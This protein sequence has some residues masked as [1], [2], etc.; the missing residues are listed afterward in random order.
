PMGAV[1]N[2]RRQ[3][4]NAERN[5]PYVAATPSLGTVD[6]PK[7][8]AGRRPPTP[9]SFHNL[10]F[11]AQCSSESIATLSG[12]SIV[13]AITVSQTQRQVSEHDHAGRYVTD[14]V[15]MHRN[16]SSRQE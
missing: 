8:H 3:L 1:D 14:V 10:S 16:R 4:R 13:P 9:P 5:R 6:R 11:C 15:W 2:R 7:H 12:A